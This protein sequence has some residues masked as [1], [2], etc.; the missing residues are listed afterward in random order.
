MENHPNYVQEYFVRR[1]DVDPM[2]YLKPG[3]LLRYA[4]QISMDQ[5]AALGF[6]D[7]FYK[8]NHCAFLL[9]KQGLVFYRVPR[10]DETLTLITMPEKTRR[11]SNRR[12]TQVQDA[13]GNLVAE[14]CSWWV[15]IDV[16]TRKILRG[17]CPAIDQYWNEQVD[18]AVTFRIPKA[19][20]LEPK[21]VCT[22]N[23]TN[24]DTNRHINNCVYADIACAAIPLEEV[25][26]KPVRTMMVHYHREIPL[27][28]SVAL[29][30]GRVED[31]WYVCG[32]RTSDGLP[33][34]EAYCTL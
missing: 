5:C 30:A 21:G 7:A 2:G 3:A 23:Y 17:G 27:G 16:Q 25:L 15:M 13:A 29:E 6:D 4:Q 22:A 14:I 26:Q 19:E 20:A 33:S 11:A 24:C 18:S 28:D 12:I 10:Y 34:F 8:E 32:T 31:G 1:S 9:A